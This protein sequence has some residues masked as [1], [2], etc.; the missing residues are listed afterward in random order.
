MSVPII[1]IPTITAFESGLS[2][3]GHSGNV[4]KLEMSSLSLKQRQQL[5][6]YDLYKYITKECVEQDYSAKSHLYA[7]LPQSSYGSSGRPIV[8][9]PQSLY[10]LCE[11]S[12]V[13]YK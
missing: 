2:G 10:Q 13:E 7:N 8:F 1:H 12:Q 11:V 5:T 9:S 3:V 4:K 6:D